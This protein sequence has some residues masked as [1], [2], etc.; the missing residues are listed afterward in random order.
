[1]EERHRSPAGRFQIADSSAQANYVKL[2]GRVPG[3]SLGGW[4]FSNMPP[5]ALRCGDTSRSITHEHPR[6]GPLICDRCHSLKQKW[7]LCCGLMTNTETHPVYVVAGTCGDETQYWAA[8][9]ARRRAAQEVR[10]VLGPKWKTTVLD[11]RLTPERIA[12]LNLTRNTVR[13]IGFAELL[14]PSAKGP[15]R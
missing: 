9:V 15:I 6:D 4:N 11:W 3:Q 14:K 2:A 13:R 12:K 7:L 1:M 8:A 5:P 10:N